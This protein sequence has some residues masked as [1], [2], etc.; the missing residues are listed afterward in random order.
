MDNI[1]KMNGLV[2]YLTDNGF[3]YENDVDMSTVYF[4]KIYK[5]EEWLFSLTEPH[6]GN[7]NK[8]LWRAEKIE[9][10]DRWGNAYFEDKY[11]SNE[12]FISYAIKEFEIEADKYNE[13]DDEA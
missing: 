12:D 8:W 4:S 7:D 13:E 6:N 10:F 1:E 11:M 9:N 5:E 2:N 3:K